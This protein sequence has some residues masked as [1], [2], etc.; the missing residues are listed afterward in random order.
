MAE[1]HRPAPLAL[2]RHTMPESYPSDSVYILGAG[3]IGLMLAAHISSVAP[4]A[5]VG[6]PGTTKNELSFRYREAEQERVVTVPRCPVDLLD[7]RVGQMIVCTKAQDALAA[8]QQVAHCLDADSKLLLMQNGMGSQEAIVAAFP[9]LSIYAAS[10]TEG[11]YRE[12]SDLVVHAGRGLTRIGSMSGAAFD[13]VALLGSAGLVA[14][15]AEPISRY[16][17]DKLRINCLINPLT[18]IHDCRNGALLELPATLA[19][20]QKLGA[21][22]DAVLAAAGFGFDE[23]AFAVATRV[24]KSTAGNRSSMLQDARAGRSLELPYM[25]GYLLRLAERHDVPA[26]EHRILVDEVMRTIGS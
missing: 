5:L 23:P 9:D 22:A 26:D 21:E 10:S 6:R 15:T 14:E 18:V 19:R 16:L 24:A 20:M 4:V 7:V 25:N 11:A 13:W 12:S 2:K 3:S 17:A 8:V 1:S